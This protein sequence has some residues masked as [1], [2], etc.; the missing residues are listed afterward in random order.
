MK[1][2]KRVEGQWV[3]PETMELFGLTILPGAHLSAPE[4]KTL[5]M[6]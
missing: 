2:F 4:G 3:V 6:T 5:V 1:T